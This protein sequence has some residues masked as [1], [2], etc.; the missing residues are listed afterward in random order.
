MIKAKA[1]LFGTLIFLAA[2]S[3]F[4]NGS[5]E[6]GTATKSGGAEKV[7][8]YAWTNPANMDDLIAAFNKKYAG[9][10]ELVYQKMADA[11]T[12][13]INTA[14]ASGAPISVMTQASAFDL[15]QRADSGVFL[16]LKQFFDKAG[17]NYA[18]VFGKSVEET[19]NFNGD[20]YAVPYANNINMV[21]YNKKLFDAAGVPYPS[22]DWTW[23]DF[24]AIA[25]KLTHGTGANEVYGAMLDVAAPKG[26]QY[27]ATIAQQKLGS[28]WYYGKDFKTTRFND[29][30]VKDSL[31]FFYNLFMVDKSAVPLSEYTA[32]KYNNDTN[33]MK[34]LYSDRYAMWIAPVYGSLYLM[35]SYGEVPAGT[36]IGL[37]NLP[38]PDGFSQSV[39]TTYS[40]QASIPKNTPDK[41]ASW[42]ALRMATIDNA[43]LY[44]GQKAM[45]PGY[46]FSSNSAAEAFYNMIFTDKPGLDVSEAVKTML[47]PRELISKDN[48]HLAGQ[49][50]INELIDA[51]MTRVFNGEMSVDEALS[52]LQTKGD[53]YI[54]NYSNN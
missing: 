50:K 8:W 28:F 17:L 10:Y 16:G 38:R 32:L 41:E 11:A 40:S 52:D 53:Q 6:Q 21:F 48:T 47:L 26:D 14:L 18:K 23:S 24:R 27:W 42:D 43:E 35:K 51:D 30:A 39:S 9:K 19:M 31:Q 34:G 29:P 49:A 12:L 22:A 54:A 5:S 46:Q 20:Y 45:N 3:V 2:A 4:A 1:L 33:G 7:Y 25:K 13:T 37:A 44:A 36:D 15:R